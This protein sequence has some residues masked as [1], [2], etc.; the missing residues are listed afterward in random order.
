MGVLRTHELSGMTGGQSGLG[1]A[2]II[3]GL[4]GA[5]ASAYG[6]YEGAKQSDKDR[7]ARRQE[8]MILAEQREKE[9]ALKAESD[10]RN[11]MV[12]QAQTHSRV[13][14]AQT[15][16]AALALIGVIG[17]VMWGLNGMSAAAFSGVAIVGA[18]YLFWKLQRAR[19]NADLFAGLGRQ[20]LPPE[21]ASRHVDAVMWGLK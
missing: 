11:A 5:G 15:G 19:E 12:R 14:A 8:L 1:Y 20:L 2:Q 17:A 10:R 6:T 13:Q 7:K 3:A 4:V 9:L 18:V 21:R 16:F